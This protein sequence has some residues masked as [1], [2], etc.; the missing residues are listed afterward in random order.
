MFDGFV[1]F[2]REL[3]GTNDFI[4]LHEPRFFGNEKKYLMDTIDSTF[5]SSV[6]K[7]VNDFE[8]AVAEYTGA[9]YAIATV[10]GTAALHTALILAGVQN[11]DEVITQSLTFVATC[12]S[13]R[14]CNAE[15][16]FV[17]VSRETLGLSAE[18]MSTFLEEHCEMRNDGFCWNKLSNKIVRACVPMHTFGFPVQLDEISNLCYRYNIALVEDAAESLGSTYKEQHTGTIGMLSA[19]SFNGNKIITTGGGG[20]LL[21]NDKALAEKAKHITTTAKVICKW[22]FEHDEVGFNYR[23][24]NLNA[25]LGLAQMESLPRILEGKREVAERYQAWGEDNGIQF[26]KEP[27]QTVSNYWMNTAITTDVTQ[28]DLMLEQTNNKGVMTRSAWKPMHELPMNS[29]CQ[30]M[31]LANTKWLF[32]RLVNVPSSVAVILK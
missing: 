23:L 24:P 25:A 13:I 1:E 5:V 16:V 20:M 26:I 8:L 15:P 11:G 31:E 3:Y 22:T 28:R 6:G 17:D 14:Y 29:Q 10:N 30:E 4:P 27:I 19:V 9:N 7:Y 2:V 21:T 32:E 18:S 12:N